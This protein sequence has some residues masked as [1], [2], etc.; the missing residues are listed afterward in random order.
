[1][2]VKKEAQSLQAYVTIIVVISLALAAMQVYVKRGLQAKVKDIADAFISPQ[3]VVSVNDYDA[4]Y[5]RLT[6]YNLE[7]RYYKGG[8]TEVKLRQFSQSEGVSYVYDNP[9]DKPKRVNNINVT[10][11]DIVPLPEN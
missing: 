7:S 9:E 11:E 6:H 8:T 2:R 10:D 3:Q 1:M 4:N 5:T